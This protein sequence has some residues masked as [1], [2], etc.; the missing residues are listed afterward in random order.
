MTSATTMKRKI[1][2]ESA[3]REVIERALAG[4]GFD[5]IREGGA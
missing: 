5:E 1:P 3:A 2:W 4:A